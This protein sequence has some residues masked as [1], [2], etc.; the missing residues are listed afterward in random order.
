[1][2]TPPAASP[3]APELHGVSSHQ[4]QT[5]GGMAAPGKGMPRHHPLPHWGGDHPVCARCTSLVLTG[6]PGG[7]LGPYFPVSPGGPR[8]PGGPGGPGGPVAP[9]RP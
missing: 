3:H 4:S 6:G 5:A 2:E 9:S 1:M 7:P 8:A